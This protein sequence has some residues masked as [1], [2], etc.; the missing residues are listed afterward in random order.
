MGTFSF[1]P[2]P[3]LVAPESDEV[4]DRVVDIGAGVGAAVGVVGIAVGADVGRVVGTVVGG[5]VGLPVGVAVGARVGVPVG[6]QVPRLQL[7]NVAPLRYTEL[8][9]TEPRKAIESIL[10]AELGITID[11]RTPQKAKASAPILWTEL[12]ITTTAKFGQS[13]KALVPML[14]TVSGIR[15]VEILVSWKD[16]S[17]MIVTELPTSRPTTIDNKV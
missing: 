6:E 17:P 16:E 9:H 12:P 4:G 1:P 14:K 15:M 10:V 2:L 5:D 11:A 7:H 3:A 13:L 8:L